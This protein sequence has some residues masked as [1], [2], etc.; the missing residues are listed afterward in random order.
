MGP[1]SDVVAESNQIQGLLEP[2]NNSPPYSPRGRNLARTYE[3]SLAR[4]K[5]DV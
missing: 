4:Q 2:R 3:F 5:H 1:D